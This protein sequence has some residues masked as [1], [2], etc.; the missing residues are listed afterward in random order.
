MPTLWIHGGPIPTCPCGAAGDDQ[1]R[2]YGGG[3]VVHWYCLVCERF[4]DPP[5]DWDD[6]LVPISLE[7]WRA[8][9]QLTV[10]ADWQ[11]GGQGFE[12]PKLHSPN[13]QVRATPLVVQTLRRSCHGT[14]FA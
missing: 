11:A 6:P 9:R 4:R 2:R 8:E 3:A 1:V 12:S 5:A 7:D 10:V 13:S 14:D